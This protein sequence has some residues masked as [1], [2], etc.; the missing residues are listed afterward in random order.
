[1]HVI[2]YAQ[3]FDFKKSTQQNTQMYG[4]TEGMTEETFRNN[5]LVL[6]SKGEKNM[7]KTYTQWLSEERVKS[8]RMEDWGFGRF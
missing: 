6:S 3:K 5:E 1:M 8:I 7:R 2:K 4:H